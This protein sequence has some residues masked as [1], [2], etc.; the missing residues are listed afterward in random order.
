YDG[1][2]TVFRVEDRAPGEGDAPEGGTAGGWD[3]LRAGGY[4]RPPALGWDRLSS[5]PVEVRPVPGDHLTLTTEPIV[6][7][8]AALWRECLDGA[9]PERARRQGA[10]ATAVRRR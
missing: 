7:T 4:R 1:P 8:V 10:Q 3:E 2:I 9:G 6:G 5:R